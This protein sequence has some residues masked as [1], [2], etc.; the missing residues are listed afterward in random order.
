MVGRCFVCSAR[1]SVSCVLLTCFTLCLCAAPYGDLGSLFKNAA[2]GGHVKPSKQHPSCRTS[3]GCLSTFNDT[4]GSAVCSRKTNRRTRCRGAAPP[5]RLASLVVS[6][7]HI[8]R[9]QPLEQPLC[10]SQRQ[11]NRGRDLLVADTGGSQFLN[12][13]ALPRG[14]DHFLLVDGE[15][16]MISGASRVP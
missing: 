16:P 1:W 14:A 8:A 6:W 3:N 5:E 7:L 10:R 13:V 9:A 2:C 12:G 4:R 15:K 11:A